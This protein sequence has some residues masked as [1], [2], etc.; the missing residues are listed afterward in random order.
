MAKILFVVL[1]LLM[2]GD[3][4]RAKARNMLLGP[5][6]PSVKNGMGPMGEFMSLINRHFRQRLDKVARFSDATLGKF[7]GPVLL[8]VGDRDPMLDSAETVRR[9]QQNMPQ[10]EVLLLDNVGHAVIGQTQPVSEFLRR[11][12]L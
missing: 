6:P 5:L 10:T 12:L 4:G 11:T 1:P 8:V 2:L 9:Q 7:A 3:W